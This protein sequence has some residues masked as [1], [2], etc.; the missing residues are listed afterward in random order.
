MIK[1]SHILIM[2]DILFSPIR[3][4]QLEILIENSVEKAMK[5][6][7]TKITPPAEL[8]EFFTIEE[9]AKLLGITKPTI[10]S[11]N[12]RGELPGVCKRG[13]K[14]YFDR[15]VLLEWLRSSRKL[16]NSEIEAEAHTYLKKRGGKNG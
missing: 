14:L 10:Y 2:N 11:K 16:S 13:K 3:L 6:L 8:P 1:L 15:K 7:P 9:V 5:N 12:S 4:N